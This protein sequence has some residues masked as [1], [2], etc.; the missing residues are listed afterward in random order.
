QNEAASAYQRL[1]EKGFRE[2]V[3]SYLETLDARNQV[4]Q[5][6]LLVNINQY[7]VFIAE[8]I[9]EREQASFPLENK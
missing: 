2:G 4:I 6:R 7:K 5:S 1:I 9:L 3:N 8:A